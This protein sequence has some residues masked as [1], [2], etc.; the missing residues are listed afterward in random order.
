MKRK[1][2]NVTLLGADCVNVERL[3]AAM[4]I[5][6]E[7]IEFGAIKLLTSLETDD[8]RLVN[9]PHIGSIEA[10]SHFCIAD[11]VQYVD[12]DFVLVVQYD[13]F[14]LNPD[15][16]REE[17]LNYDYIG[18][19][20]LVD[21]W[22]VKTFDLPH[23]LL[24]SRMV[25]NGGFS[26]RSKKFLETSAQLMREGKIPQP[27]PEDVALCAWHRNL[28]EDRGISFAPVG[29]ASDFSIEGEVRTYD[30][31]FGFHGF[32][33]TNIDTW[34]EEHPEHSLVA[35]QYRNARAAY[36]EHV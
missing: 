7:K 28:L 13:G 26:L 25:G 23:E 30:A 32:S 1:L 27:Q 16:W 4:D 35:E 36:L 20:W 2:E 18:A 15:S 19:P 31:Q 34:I 5:C 29:V 22:A 10:Y 8:R 17:F 21:D 9:I 24:G 11:L 14:V 3:Q 12:T 33:W 6:Q